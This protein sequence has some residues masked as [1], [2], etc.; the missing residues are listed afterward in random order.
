MTARFVWWDL[1]S[2]EADRAKDFY[3]ALFG[4]TLQ[5]WRPE[6]APAG[7]PAYEMIGIDGRF[8]GGIN[9]IPKDAPA[10]SHWMGHIGVTDLDAA[11]KR[12]AAAGATFPMGAME[13]PTVGRMGMMIDPQGAVA[14]LFQPAGELPSV[15]GA[16]VPG[17]VGWNELL[18]GDPAASRSF[19][20]DVVGWRWRGGPFAGMGYE[21]FGTGEEGGD[22]GGMMKKPDEVPVTAWFLY[23]TSTDLDATVKR[24]GELG[25]TVTSPPFAVEQVGRLAIAMAPDGSMF[26]VAQWAPKP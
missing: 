15:P 16:D 23:F 1:N 2:K 26:A 21:L 9:Q 3:R 13:I 6:G 11:M 25:G 14:S 19:Y 20:S 7:M 4:W 18:T 24:I 10:P 12:A 5:S 17:M 22:A 8:F